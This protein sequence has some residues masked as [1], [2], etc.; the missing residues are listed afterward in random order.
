MKSFHQFLIE[1]D[2]PMSTNPAPVQPQGQVPQQ[3][4]QLKVPDKKAVFDFY[5]NINDTIDNGVKAVADYVNA[6][7]QKNQWFEGAKL[8]NL[9]T[10]IKQ[11]VRASEVLLRPLLQIQ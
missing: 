8:M 10:K 6:H 7:P 4:Q 5:R 2:M 3:G 11:D 1:Q 9:Y